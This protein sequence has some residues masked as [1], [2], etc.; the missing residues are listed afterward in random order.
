[1]PGLYGFSGNTSNVAVSSTPGLYI[2]S[3]ASNILN[4]AEQLLNLLSNNGTVIFQLDPAYG[5]SKVEAFAANGGGGGGNSI[6]NLVGDVTGFGST[7]SPLYT[8]ISN[9]A[10]TAGHYGSGNVIPVFN[11]NSQGRITAAS[12]TAIDL[13]HYTGNV[14]ASNVIV[15]T[16]IFYANGQPFVSSSYGNA[17]VAAYLPVYTGNIQAQNMRILGNLSIAGNTFFTNVNTIVT[18]SITANSG[19]PSTSTTTGAIIATGTGG[20]GI[21]G[22]GWFG[23]AL[24]S[25]TIDTINANIGAFETYANLTFSTVANAASQQTAINTINANVGA[26]ETYT[27]TQIAT[28]NTN[29]N[30]YETY[31]NAAINSIVTGANANVQTYLS[32]LS[33]IKIGLGANASGTNSIAIG[34]NAGKTSQGTQGIALGDGAG[35]TSQSQQ[36]IAIGTSAGSSGQGVRAVAIGQSAGLTNQGTNSIAIGY[37]AGETNQ[38]SNGIVLNASGTALNGPNSG[39]YVN[40]IRND[41]SQFYTLPFYNTGTS[42]ITYSTPQLMLANTLPNYNGNLQT[43]NLWVTGGATGSLGTN[44]VAAFTQG[45]T[46]DVMTIYPQ[47]KGLGSAIG[48]YYANLQLSPGPVTFYNQIS[49]NQGIVASGNVTAYGLI[50]ATGNVTIPSYN[51]TGFF[52]GNLSGNVSG[53]KVVTGS[54]Y[55]NNYLYANGVS[56]LST[57]NYGNTQVAAYLPTYNGSIGTDSS[58]GADRNIAWGY[59]A[60]TSTSGQRSIGIGNYAGQTTQG[61]GAVAL[62]QNAGQTSQGLGA[63]AIGRSTAATSQGQYAVA[64]GWTAG[65][66]NQAN[67]GIAIGNGAGGTQSGTNAIAIGNQAGVTQSASSIILSSTG[68]ALNDNGIAGFFVNPVR[69]DTGNVSLAVYYNTTTKELTYATASAGSTYGNANVAAYLPY[70]TGSIGTLYGYLPTINAST[71]TIPS[72]ALYTGSIQPAPGTTDIS[73]N[74]AGQLYLSGTATGVPNGITIIG[75]GAGFPSTGNTAGA[76]QI[77]AKRV[78]TNSTYD[79]N[80]V[81]NGGYVDFGN[82]LISTANIINSTANIATTQ[83]FIGD[84]S[85]L[86]NLPA[87][88]SYGNSNVAA[89]LPTDPTITGIQANIGA[90]ETYANV[91]FSTQAN[92]A[93]QQTQINTNTA[94]LATLN[95]NVGA[96]ETYANVTFS[97]VANATSQQTQIDTLNAN[98]GA[99]ETYANATFITSATSY[100]NTQVAAYLATNTDPTISS[101]NANAAVQAGQINTLFSNAATQQTAINSINANVGAFE[102]YANLSLTSLAT[103][104]NANT[105]AYMNNSFLPGYAGNL[106]FVNNFS[107]SNIVSTGLISA[108]NLVAS[109]NGFFW[110][111]NGQPYSTGSSFTGNLNGSTLYDSV[112]E[113][114]FANAFPLSTPYNMPNSSLNNYLINAPVYNS[115]LLS[116]P[117]GATGNVA[118]S[119]TVV[120]LIASA[121]VTTANSGQT[122]TNRNTVGSLALFSMTPNANTANQ[123]RYRAMNAILDLNLNNKTLGNTSVGAGGQGQFAFIGLGGLTNVMGAGAVGSAMGLNGG[124]QIAPYAGTAN[125]TYATGQMSSV[126]FVNNTGSNIA[127]VQY[128]RLISGSISGF[129]ANSTVANAVGLH[130]FNGWAGTVGSPTAGA[131]NAYAVLNEDASTIIQSAGNIVATSGAYFIGDGSKLTGIATGSTYGNANVA[132]Y[133]P[134]DPTITGIQANIGAFETYA[135]VTFATKSALQTLD[136]NVGAYETYA[137]LTFSTTANAASQQ[138]QIN[139]L[140][141]EFAT[142]DANVGLY[143]TTTNAN[144]GTIYTNLNTL[145]AN[146][147]AFETYANSTFSTSTYSNTNVSAYLA[148]NISTPIGT[149]ANVYAGNVILPGNGTFY[150]NLIAANIVVANIGIQAY[151]N[152][153]SVGPPAYARGAV[154]YDNT[155]DSL[156]YYNSVTNNEV[157]V[158]QELQFNAYNGTGSTI[159]QGTPVYL[160]GGQFNTNPNIAPAIAN[161]IATSQVAG[162]ANQDIPANTLGCVVTVGIVAN[163][164]MGTFSVGDTLYLSPYSAGQ[165][166]NTQPPTG[167]VVK[168]GTV[169]YNNS[170]NGRFLVNKTVP[171]NNQYFGNLT[172]TGNLSANN[173]SIT[174]KLSTGSLSTSDGIT[175]TGTVTAGNLI[176][177]SG[178]YWANGVSYASTVTGTYGNT[179]V[180][181]YLP[182]DPTITGIQANVGAFE[183]YA[184]VTFSTQANAASQQTQ[185]DTNTAGLA[186]LNA[187]VGAFETYAN[188]TFGGSSYGNTQVAA[189]LPTDPTITGIQA[190]I[191]AFETYANVTFSTQAN[192]ASQQTQIDT[193]TAGL[194]TLNANVGAY[195][196]YANTRIQTLDAN[197]GTATTNITTLFANAASQQTQI[198]TN[199]AGLATLNANVGAFETYANATFITSATQYGNTQVAAYLKAPGPIGSVTPNTGAFTTLAGTLST[200]A[201]PN[202]T[203]VGTLTSLAVGAV[204]SSGTITATTINAGTIGNLGA[205]LTGTLNTATQTNITSVGTLTGLKS[206]GNVVVSSGTDTTSTTTGA[207]VLTGSG[208]ASIGGNAYVGNNL[209][210]G[211]TALAQ[212]ASF[213]NPTIIAVDSG[214]NYAQIALKN[215][216]SNGSADFAAYADNGTDAGGWVDVGFAGSTYN[217]PN[218]TITKPQDG[219]LLVRP[220]SNTYGGNLIIGTSEAGSYND[221]VIGVGSFY[222]NAEVARFHGNTTNSGTFNIAVKTTVANITSTNGY[223]WANGTA[224]STGGS[225]SSFTGNLAGSTLYD[226]VNQRIFANAFPLSTP[227]NSINGSGFSNY[228]LNAPV[229]ASGQLQ[230]PPTP[231]AAQTI[232]S[233]VT[234]MA[235]TSNVG[236]LS[237]NQSSNNRNT[238]T[239]ISYGQFMPVGTNPFNNTDRVRGF[240]GQADVNLN[241]K[242][243]GT[244]NSSAQNAT[245]IN[246]ITAAAIVMGAGSAGAVVGGAGTIQVIPT[247]NNQA[248]VQ[249]ASGIFSSIALQNTNGATAQGNIAYARLLGG[250]VSGFSSNLTVQNAIGLHTYSGWAGNVGIPGQGATTSYA[251][252]NEDAGTQIQTNGNVTMSSNIKL[253]TGQ[254]VSYRDKV[255]NLGLNNGALTFDTTQAPTY[256]L[257]LNGTLTLSTSSFPGMT[258]GTSLTLVITQYSSGGPY[259]LST[260]GIKWAGGSN[261][262]STAANAIDIINFYYD[263]TNYYGSLVKGY[264]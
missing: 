177:T 2:G 182:T 56:I 260:S 240:V 123:D 129:N 250:T 84:G 9:T 80:I 180:A 173:A 144:I 32:S 117:P 212:Q 199:T 7:G 26:F 88:S 40:P 210:I 51:P 58:T 221:I 87:S 45:G 176:T 130:T 1:M 192:A 3:G 244:M 50:A 254:L 108:A 83:F 263:G 97:T 23:G 243:W 120:N 12:N 113:R 112:N 90:F 172:L 101:L 217:D 100:G 154:W 99:F 8:T 73:I 75:A 226:S 64:I 118:T 137:N 189:Y 174:N 140:N 153:S 15:A 55:T 34:N 62:G 10:V 168:V 121:N 43:S 157:N 27:N 143:E 67:Y 187:N 49:T 235:I 227:S 213:A 236:L 17:N 171:V 82:S 126:A 59:L 141:T 35:Q 63:I 170:P 249:Y 91:T 202:I 72:G 136:A 185:I 237:T 106:F 183:T 178:L 238:T 71:V 257:T 138:T 262:L 89:Y 229:Y 70:Y 33:N 151:T 145:T 204:T 18:T 134:T 234:G 47:G 29:L 148:S 114:I 13:S 253:G 215:T 131:Q 208:G 46:T 133:L 161:T 61:V 158:G 22:D 159:T 44:Y 258:A 98:V 197:L 37:R 164:A 74:A 78:S 53:N 256:T 160:T 135:N 218:Y 147:G 251:V 20:L 96:F 195:E 220:T 179:Q 119:G 95:A 224:Y 124:V 186:T 139:T 155:Q 66:T 200:A 252:L 28:L 209:Y 109:A 65:A 222:S 6:I 25:P 30:S 239:S 93:S 42:E 5:Y 92:A 102:L 48:V 104:A 77:F 245:S 127:N 241:S 191:G 232:S 190:N 247:S 225:G 163:V 211:S 242:V 196:I 81:I 248:N 14:S 146:V 128:A 206:S 167:F 166:S 4:N 261:T 231:T 57:V 86:T 19:T 198:D 116:A 150:G 110:S 255:L 193:N 16:G 21:G 107:A 111:G 152:Y 36:G 85:K 216:N 38:S 184:N 233:I 39:F 201:Q 207:L 259:T 169:L 105:A 223:F 11:V 149:T 31:A 219:S 165:V 142:L 52:S 68:T 103:G 41:N 122:S 246:G 228:F 54:I 203:S 69:N 79:G 175:A 60:Q 162:V 125:I 194:A 76:V 115:G 24:H 205:T 156:A 188:L 264:V 132:A 94:G 214:S 181:A 230:G